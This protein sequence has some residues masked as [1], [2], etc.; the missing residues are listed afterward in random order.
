[1]SDEIDMICKDMF[2]VCSRLF[3][4]RAV[5]IAE[6]RYLVK[7]LETKKNRD[8]SKVF[9]EISQTIEKVKTLIPECGQL[10]NDKIPHIHS[11]VVKAASSGLDILGDHKTDHERIRAEHK[12]LRR[13]EWEEFMVEMSKAQSDVLQK[14]EQRMTELHSKLEVKS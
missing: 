1:M 5:L 9:W 13:Q 8:S 10:L 7:E 12:A 3:N 4:H 14:H 6:S 11:E 2:G